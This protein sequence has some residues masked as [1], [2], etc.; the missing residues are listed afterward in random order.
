[1][2]S[3]D[4][5]GRWSSQEALDQAVS[6]LLTVGSQEATKQ[7]NPGITEQCYI[8]R[9]ALRQC[10]QQHDQVRHGGLRV[11]TRGEQAKGHSRP[12]VCVC[13]CVESLS[14]VQLFVFGLQKHLSL[15]AG[16]SRI[17]TLEWVAIPF[18]KKDLPNWGSNLES[19]QLP[20]Q[21][22]YG[23][24]HREAPTADYDAPQTEPATCLHTPSGQ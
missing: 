18:S 17:R 2:N 24:N 9:K 20:R 5:A 8:Q 4:R 12:C 6:C 7:T 16:F 1:M 15:C 23:L 19:P 3:W 14:R 11:T 22:P 10:F 21:I 13:V